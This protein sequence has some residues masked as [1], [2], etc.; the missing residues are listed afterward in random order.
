MHD[1]ES[2]DVLHRNI[3]C[4]VKNNLLYDKELRISGSG[5]HGRT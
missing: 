1:I 3:L 2:F 4:M 5:T